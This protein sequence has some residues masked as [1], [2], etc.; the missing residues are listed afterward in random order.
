MSRIRGINLE[1]VGFQK[2]IKVMLRGIKR[3][4]IKNI[5]IEGVKNVGDI[6]I[7]NEHYIF[8]YSYDRETPS[9]LGVTYI[10]NTKENCLFYFFDEKGEMRKT[11]VTDDVDNNTRASKNEENTTTVGYIF[12][13]KLK[14]KN[15]GTLGIPFLLKI[16]YIEGDVEIN[17]NG[18]FFVY[19]TTSAIGSKLSLP[20]YYRPFYFN[21]VLLLI[22]A[23]FYK[24]ENGVKEY[25]KNG[26]TLKNFLDNN[27]KDDSEKTFNTPL[28]IAKIKKDSKTVHYNTY[29][30]FKISNFKII[31][32]GIKTIVINKDLEISYKGIVYKIKNKKDIEIEYS[33]TKYGIIA[34]TCDITF[35]GG[36]NKIVVTFGAEK[37]GDVYEIDM[38][39]R[40]EITKNACYG[41]L[42]YSI[43]N[44][45]S[46]RDP[47]SNT[48][49]TYKLNNVTLSYIGN[50]SMGSVEIKNPFRCYSEFLGYNDFKEESL[51]DKRGQVVYGITEPFRLEKT[52]GKN[53]IK[54][55]THIMRDGRSSETMGVRKNV[56]TTGSQSRS[57]SEWSVNIKFKADSIEGSGENEIIKPGEEVKLYFKGRWDTKATFDNWL[58]YYGNTITL[59][60]KIGDNGEYEEFFKWGYFKKRKQETMTYDFPLYL[61]KKGGKYYITTNL[62]DASVYD[63][64][65]INWSVSYTLIDLQGRGDVKVSANYDQK[66]LNYYIKVNRSGL[67]CCTRTEI[68]EYEINEGTCFN[69]N[70]RDVYDNEVVQV[71]SEKIDENGK[72][73]ELI[74][75]PYY[76]IIF[77]TSEW[78]N[79]SFKVEEAHP[80]GEEN[81]ETA[82]V[83]HNDVKFY[84]DIVLDKDNKISVKGV[85][86][87]KVRYFALKYYVDK[88]D[89]NDGINKENELG[90]FI[91]SLTCFGKTENDEKNGDRYG[92]VNTYD[93]VYTNNGKHVYTKNWGWKGIHTYFK[94]SGTNDVWLSGKETNAS[95][96]S[97]TCIDITDDLSL[98]YKTKVDQSWTCGSANQ[99][100][101]VIGVYDDYTVLDN[102]LYEEENNNM[103]S[104]IERHTNRFAIIRLYKI[105]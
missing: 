18:Y 52:G 45:C 25:F 105:N 85:T 44:G 39:T 75:N 17:E 42:F 96:T 31:S 23:S 28:K 98:A 77:D 7:D 13:S 83:G 73:E 9:K 74:N 102:D 93:Y 90:T 60:C 6:N 12:I 63:Y 81:Y 35:I 24:E 36:E 43:S 62:S 4:N 11:D 54:K 67:P 99:R 32:E 55:T 30:N 53:I 94:L 101:W 82:F 37:Q 34:E 104:V 89:E 91:E 92:G 46:I 15:S 100:N 59:D 70:V 41:R 47:Y 49:N 56:E 95:S 80:D 50:K 1:N 86:S 103:Y 2:P 38:S 26:Q 51:S 87:K 78:M 21:S 71:L 57:L 48:N 5:S 88:N 97:H 20:L 72:N 8:K 64:V 84:D 76:D 65:T 14:Y 27:V 16:T 29:N 68:K 22:P 10:N 69:K 79:F 33:E 40:L 19:L 66:I 3:E 61:Y 58:R